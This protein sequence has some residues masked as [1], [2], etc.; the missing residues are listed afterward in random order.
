MSRSL[1]DVSIS[2]RM[3]VRV[4]L[5]AMAGLLPIV[6][7]STETK[8]IPGEPC[9]GGVLLD[10][11]TTC[12]PKCD[13]AACKDAN[14]CVSNICRLKCDAHSACIP[15]SQHC[16]T[17]K[18]DDTGADVTVCLDRGYSRLFGWLGIGT[19]C[20]LGQACGQAYCVD[21]GSFCDPAACNGNPAIC[22]AN[23][24]TP[25]WG[26]C[27]D[28][29]QPCLATSCAAADC[30]YSNY[31]PNG[32]QCD[33]LACSGNPAA[34][35]QNET[36]CRAAAKV[37]GVDEDTFLASCNYGSCGTEDG[38]PSCVFN[39]CAASACRGLACNSA[40]Q[41]DPHAYC[42]IDDCASD[43]ACPAG[44]HCGTQ[45]V[46]GR[47]CGGT[48]TGGTCA[49]G[50]RDGKSCTSD[51]SCQKGG[52]NLCPG[53]DDVAA[54]CTDPSVFGADDNSYAEGSFCLM[55][56]RCLVNDE[57]ATCETDKDCALGAGEIC[58]PI[59]DVKVCARM[60]DDQANC[61]NDE[62]CVEADGRKACLPA[63]GSCRGGGSFCSHC[64]DDFDCGDKDSGLAC[65]VRGCY[66]P[67]F[68]TSCEID[69]DCPKSPS[70]ANGFCMKE[71]VVT[72]SS[73]VYKKCYFPYN[74][75]AGAFGCYPANIPVEPN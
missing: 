21:D 27:S 52:S 58:A 66:D 34:C 8:E 28:T 38:A 24:A 41:G 4:V 51:G 14:V 49:G 64:V 63:S 67:F 7:C 56:N 32:A 47:I 36:A 33:L 57:C 43:A 29:A 1:A 70:G 5:V 46:K 62:T 18:E 74:A 68:L 61:L 54:P 3:I 55:R 13:P 45:R 15:E 20:A 50:Y 17:A 59:G 11:G 40:G 69:L 22:V 39:T 31:C 37:A 72:P 60:C 71:P 25:G 73:S 23:P 10:D 30:R 42:T 44:Y 53:N 19:K 6:A 2:F 65:D 48:C 35:V 75:D 26:T 12:V 9:V 16:G